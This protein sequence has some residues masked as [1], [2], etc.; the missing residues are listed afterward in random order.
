MQLTR[1]VIDGLWRCICPSIDLFA[2]PQSNPSLQRSSIRQAL[3]TTK[4][5][6]SRPSRSL[7]S[8]PIHGKANVKLQGRS[9]GT[10]AETSGRTSSTTL[11]AVPKPTPSNS[12]LDDVPV[13]ELHDTLR[14][15]DAKNG[16]YRSISDLVGYLIKSRGE[17]P[18]LLHYDALIRAN[19]DASKGSA[20]A[21]ANL[22][23]EV[24][25]ENI[26]PDSSLYH[27]ALRV[28]LWPT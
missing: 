25:E 27:N 17:I 18:S 23:R 11:S 14:N 4:R 1:I 9:Y 8:H 10:V 22:L 7:L 2:F 16:A 12:T 5:A 24:K 20:E 6:L 19:A 3:R 21:V 28:I 26:I 13:A 15:I